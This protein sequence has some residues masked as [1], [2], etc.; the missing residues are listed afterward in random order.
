MKKHIILFL[1]AFFA[2]NIT[3]AQDKSNSPK[4]TFS[5]LEYNYGN[6]AQNSDG[7]C[8][9]YY[10]NVGTAPLVLNSVT[11]S[12]GCTTPEWSKKPLLPGKIGKIKVKYNT[13]QLGEFRKIICVKSNAVNKNPIILRIQG[14][15]VK[16]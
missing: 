8:H 3:F 5:Y 11:T 6:I 12:C 14:K 15:V 1:T 7:T 4:I 9:F 2:V 16:Q 13:S 10:K